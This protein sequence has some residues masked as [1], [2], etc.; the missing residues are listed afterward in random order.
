MKK[1]LSKVIALT[2]L[3]VAGV[4]TVDAQ[5]QVANNRRERILYLISRS[6][7]AAIGKKCLFM[8]RNSLHLR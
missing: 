7:Q 1:N 3:A 5:S 6:T 2:L 8:V 4:Q